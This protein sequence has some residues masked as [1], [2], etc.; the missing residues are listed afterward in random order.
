SDARLR[1]Q[2]EHRSEA[3]SGAP[4]AEDGGHADD[5]E[6]GHDRRGRGLRADAVM[7][8][9]VHLIAGLSWDPAIR[10]I[11]SVGVGVVVLIG[12]VYLLLGT[13]I[14]FKLGARVSASGLFGFLSILTLIWWIQPP[15]IG[16]RGGVD[17]H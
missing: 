17:P 4:G 8:G 14:G 13:N 12:S 9:T 3:G 5:D 7:L 15:G 1:H 2:P 10:G 11:L 6:P 16:P